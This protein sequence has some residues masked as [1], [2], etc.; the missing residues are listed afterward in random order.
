MEL[1]GKKVKMPQGF[2]VLLELKKHEDELKAKGI[3]FN[4][5]LLYEEVN[6]VLS[7]M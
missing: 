3:E 4:G 7:R 1:E 5:K 6:E 2:K